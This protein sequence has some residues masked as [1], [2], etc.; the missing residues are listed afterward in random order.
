MEIHQRPRTALQANGA[1]PPSQVTTR[2]HTRITIAHPPTV[3]EWLYATCRAIAFSPTLLVPI[4]YARKLA[5]PVRRW[6]GE[7]AVASQAYPRQFTASQHCGHQ[8]L[9]AARCTYISVPTD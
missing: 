9:F 7:F 8:S 2:S 5:R 1:A 3:K 4:V 6:M